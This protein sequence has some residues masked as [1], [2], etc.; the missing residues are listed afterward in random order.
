[1]ITKTFQYKP[2]E[3]QNPYIGF[4]SFQH[5]R[6]EKL[7]SDITVLPERNFTETENFECYPVPSDVPENGREE[8]YYPDTSIVYIRFLWK[9]F[10]PERGKYNYKFF[11]DILRKARA[12][13]QSVVIRLIAHS[14]REEDDVPDWLK[15]IISCPAR[16]AGER[17][18]DSPTDPK[19]IEYFSEAVLALGKHFDSD[20]TLDMVDISLPGSWGEGHKLHLYSQEDLKTLVDAYVTAFP[21]T[22]LVGQLRRPDLLHYVNQ[23]AQVGLRGDGLGEPRHLR[24]IYPPQMEKISDLWKTAPVSFEAYWWLCEWQRRGWDIDEIIEKTLSWHISSFNAKSIPIPWD[25]KDKIDYWIQKMGYHFAIN[26]VTYPETAMPGQ[27]VSIE[28]VIEN[29]GVAPIY[30]DIPLKV[31]LSGE[32]EAHVFVTDVDIRTWLPGT[33]QNR[34]SISLPA[35]IAPGTYT[36]EIGITN[37]L[38]PLLY[39]C[40]DA[41]RNG[42][43]YKIGQLQMV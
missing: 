40:T 6:G 16:P 29:V 10:E 28:A 42:S 27:N 36:L 23:R 20:P 17:V 35:D 22:Q 9:E 12:H 2:E 3:G 33:H 43:F 14:T 4:T 32:K 11:E 41:V 19:F 34:F 5:F 18:K 1:M 13:S 30:K 37:D 7:Y 24:E 15:G 39:L 25:W 38:V 21:T 8:G 31:R 26:S